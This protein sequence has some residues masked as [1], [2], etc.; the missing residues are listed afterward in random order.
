MRSE[1]H[2][3]KFTIKLERDSGWHR[4]TQETRR[5]RMFA[6]RLRQ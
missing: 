5:W 4:A 3:L 6:A 1:H 2:R